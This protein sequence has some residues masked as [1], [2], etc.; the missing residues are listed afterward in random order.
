MK[1]GDTMLPQQT[2]D[3]LLFN[4]LFWSRVAP[5]CIDHSLL[6]W[7]TSSTTALAH[8]PAPGPRG[9]EDFG[10]GLPGRSLVQQTVG[11]VL[12]SGLSR[13]HSGFRAS[14]MAQGLDTLGIVEGDGSGSRWYKASQAYRRW[15]SGIYPIVS[16]GRSESRVLDCETQRASKD[17]RTIVSRIGMSLRSQE[18][19]SLCVIWKCYKNNDNECG[20]RRK[21]LCLVPRCDFQNLWSTRC[22]KYSCTFSNCA[23]DKFEQKYLN[24]MTRHEKYH[25]QIATEN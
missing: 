18:L 19:Q 22:G 20:L 9:A 5:V 21:L 3:T 14:G 25:F 13:V 4:A 24:N 17:R 1:L 7:T 15:A 8:P 6:A 16:F 2:V 11:F 12:G 23:H 10:F